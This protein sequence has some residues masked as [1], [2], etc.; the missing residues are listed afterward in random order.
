MCVEYMYICMY[1]H[2]EAHREKQR[3]VLHKTQ[4]QH[5]SETSQVQSNYSTV[6]V[7]R[8]AAM[9]AVGWLAGIKVYCLSNNGRE[10]PLSESHTRSAFSF[11]RGLVVKPGSG[12]DLLS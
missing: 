6:A 12:P 8:V 11:Q 5:L 9:A 3:N 1:M 7:A 10:A 4:T 2:R